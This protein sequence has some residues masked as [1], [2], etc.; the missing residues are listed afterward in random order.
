MKFYFIWDGID[1]ILAAPIVID[2]A[3]FLL[4]AKKKGLY[5][6]IKEMAFFFKSPMDTNVIN[7]HEQFNLLVEWFKS[8]L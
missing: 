1:A 7:T 8:N 4:F 2:I 5:G 6:V 3:R